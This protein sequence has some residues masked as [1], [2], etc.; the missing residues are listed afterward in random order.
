MRSG[1]F[2]G[3]LYLDLLELY[4]SSRLVGELC[5]LS[6]SNVYRAAMA[7]SAALDLDFSKHQGSYACVRNTDVLSRLRAAARLLR[8][9]GAQPLRFVGDYRSMVL[10]QPLP[11]GLW[12]LPQ[13]WLGSRHSLQ[14]LDAG[15]LDLLVLRSLE[16][17]PLLALHDHPL[18]VGQWTYTPTHA[19]LPLNTES[20]QL[21]VSQ[22]HPLARVAAPTP[23]QIAQYP[24]PSYPDDLFPGLRDRLRPHGLWSKRIASRSMTPGLWEDMAIQA[25]M[26]VASTPNAVSAVTERNPG[27]LVALNY[28][29]GLLDHDLLVVPIDLL[30]EPSIQSAV[31]SIADGYHLQLPQRRTVAGLS[32]ALLKDTAPVQA[33]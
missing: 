28:N 27:S 1:F 18:A 24:S 30:D 22:G 31:Q 14:A 7:L 19:L 9:R 20:V 13:T 29:T 16:L 8:A 21:Y 25:A 3:L 10:R 5:F 33:S 6:Q 11:E 32:H 4:G 26:V 15:V 12:S 23:Q 17:T 2:E